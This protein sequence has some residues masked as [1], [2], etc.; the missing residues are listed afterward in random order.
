[1]TV[2]IE[3]SCVEA[4]HV[5][6]PTNPVQ[7]ADDGVETDD[8]TAL[9]TFLGFSVK[10]RTGSLVLNGNNTLAGLFVELNHKYQC[11]YKS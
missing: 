9:L 5:D 10:V 7:V 11:V 1:M 4:P 6:Q 8:V 2:R 3:T